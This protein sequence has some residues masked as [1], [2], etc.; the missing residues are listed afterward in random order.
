MRAKTAGKLFKFASTSSDASRDVVKKVYAKKK[1][2]YYPSLIQHDFI[3]VASLMVN[4]WDNQVSHNYDV[5]GESGT[6]ILE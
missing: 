6:L 2:T 3:F 4:R 5:A 1:S